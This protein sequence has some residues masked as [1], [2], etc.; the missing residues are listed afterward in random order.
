MDRRLRPDHPSRALWAWVK[1]FDWAQE[2]NAM[3]CPRLL[4]WGSEDRQMAR[5][6]RQ[7]RDLLAFRG[8][9]FVEFPGL[10]HGAFNERVTA[11]LVVPTIVDWAARKV[12]DSW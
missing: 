2:L 8:V 3:P 9:D 5:R 12:G 4:Y 7:V 11:D 1:Q 10:D 6:L